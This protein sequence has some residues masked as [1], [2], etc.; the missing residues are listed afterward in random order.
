MAQDLVVLGGSNAL[1]EVIGIVAALKASGLEYR[2][3]GV[4]DD[5][6]HLAGKTL[7]GVP[8]LGRLEYVRHLANEL[9]VFAIGSLATQEERSMI[10]E[11]LNIPTNRFAT[12]IHPSAEIDPTASIGHGCIV[13]KGVSIGPG[14]HVGNF[15]VLAVNSA[16]GPDVTIEDF[17]MVTSFVLLLSRA[18]LQK[19][20]FIGSMSC[21]IEDIVIGNMARVGVGSIVHRNV[22]DRFLAVGNPARLL[23]KS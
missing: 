12:L 16:V 5:A 19:G 21:V 11:R 3:K 17:V 1:R 22:P 9:L 6:E 14:T 15:V 10:I 8:V 4:L 20:C 7:H 23:G 18:H 13:H 2:I